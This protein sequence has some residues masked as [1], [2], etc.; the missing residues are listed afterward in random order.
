MLSL[1]TQW[2]RSYEGHVEEKITKLKH[3]NTVNRTNTNMN[4]GFNPKASF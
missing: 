1:T 3:I 4:I 2:T